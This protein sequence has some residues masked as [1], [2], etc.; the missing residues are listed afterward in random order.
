M[1]EVKLW[2]AIRPSVHAATFVR[3]NGLFLVAIAGV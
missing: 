1:K 2:L 3:K